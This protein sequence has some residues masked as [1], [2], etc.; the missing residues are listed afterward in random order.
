MTESDLREHIDG[1]REILSN[2]EL[3]EMT[4][5]CTDNEH[6]VE[7]SEETVPPAWTLEKFADAFQQ[8]QVL[9]DKILEYD[10]SMECDLVV[11][12]GIAASLRSLQD[13]FDDAKRKQK[14]LPITMFLTGASVGI[15]A[16]PLQE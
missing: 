7:D 1:S 4:K 12:R 11:T 3:E 8:A 10:P 6:D 15:N 13:L 16:G 5:S 9:K 2:E 14:Q